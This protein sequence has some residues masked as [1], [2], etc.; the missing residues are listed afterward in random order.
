MKWAEKEKKKQH[1]Y[2]VG[3]V[4]EF[5]ANEKCYIYARLV[6]YSAQRLQINWKIP[7]ITRVTASVLGLF[8]TKAGEC[9]CL[10]AGAGD[11]VQSTL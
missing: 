5:P 2:N 3:I 10:V 9:F 4:T 6:Q 1:F 8:R 7:R 11:L